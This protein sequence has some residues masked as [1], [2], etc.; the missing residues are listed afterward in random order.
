MRLDVDAD[1]DG[2]Q[3]QLFNAARGIEYE[4]RIIPSGPDSLDFAVRFT[5]HKKGGSPAKLRA[6]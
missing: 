3:I 1:F 5:L 2:G 4:L 6:S